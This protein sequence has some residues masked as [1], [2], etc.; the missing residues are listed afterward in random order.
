[1]MKINE[2][3]VTPV[4]TCTMESDVAHVRDLMTLKNI[5]AIPVVKVDK[6]KPLV[7]GIITYH[8]LAGV[9]DD[10]VKVK[11][12]MSRTIY[13]VDPEIS[14]QKAAQI[15][16]DKKIHHLIAMKE[17]E[18]VGILSTMDFVKIVAEG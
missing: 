14:V 1:M 8:D 7:E 15:M 13:A 6:D 5:S 4:T 2:L 11:Q 16:I 3:I 17:D 18:L 10:T 12:I 9:Y